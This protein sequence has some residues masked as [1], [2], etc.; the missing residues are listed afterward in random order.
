MSPWSF[1]SQPIQRSISFDLLPLPNPLDS[2]LEKIESK[3]FNSSLNFYE[4]KYWSLLNVPTKLFIL[5]HLF[6]NMDKSEYFLDD[7]NII[8]IENTT[9]YEFGKIFKTLKLKDNFFLLNVLCSRIAIRLWRSYNN[10][11]DKKFFAKN[12][13]NSFY[14]I[15]FMTR[16]ERSEYWSLLN[17]N[18]RNT[19][20]YLIQFQKT[21]KKI[22]SV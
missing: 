12:Y 22:I 3:D 17:K 13:I 4:Q 18:Q 9:I 7:R 11:D 14:V 15:R 2:I 21:L 1:H 10:I 8:L 20:I 16:S 5:K 19:V 6:S